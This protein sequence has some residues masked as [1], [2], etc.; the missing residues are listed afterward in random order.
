MASRLVAEERVRLCSLTFPWKNMSA[1]DPPT[2][3]ELFGDAGKDEVA[4]RLDRLA[5]LLGEKRFGQ[6]AA[7]QLMLFARPEIALP[8]SLGGYAPLVREGI[9]FFLSGISYPRLR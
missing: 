6:E 4:A 5:Q 1:A 9:E 8:S 3:L 7:R 2:F